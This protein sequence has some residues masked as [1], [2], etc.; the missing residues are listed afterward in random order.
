MDRLYI[1]N[2]K[3]AN[4]IKCVINKKGLNKMDELRPPE[5]IDQSMEEYAL[6][7]HLKFIEFLNKFYTAKRGGIHDFIEISLYEMSAKAVENINKYLDEGHK[8]VNASEILHI[9]AD[10]FQKTLDQ[11]KRN[12]EKM[13][14]VSFK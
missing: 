9:T 6:A 7:V 3:C 5:Q 4:T 12:L 1:L 11:I 14:G 10:S 13:H 2:A 8:N